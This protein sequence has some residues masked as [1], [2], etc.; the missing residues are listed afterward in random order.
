M[1]DRELARLLE[2]LPD[3][4]ADRVPGPQLEAL[5]SLAEAGEYEEFLDALLAGL[6][7][8]HTLVTADERDQ[9][10]RLLRAMHLSTRP[11]T[12]LHVAA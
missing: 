10:D 5:R 12:D 4:F 9:L 6:R 8:R 3:R 11:L 7:K 2:A 1:D